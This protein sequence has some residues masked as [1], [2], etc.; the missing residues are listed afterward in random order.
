MCVLGT[1]PWSSG[2]ASALHHLAV[3]PD[4]L[5]KQNELMHDWNLLRTRG[6]RIVMN[7]MTH[8]GQ[9]AGQHSK[10]EILSSLKIQKNKKKKKEKIKQ[11]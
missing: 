10:T 5:T 9:W 7:L 3:Y 1:E 4:I 6:R 2:R 11:F 8:S